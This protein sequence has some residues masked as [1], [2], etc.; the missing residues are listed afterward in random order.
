MPSDFWATFF[1]INFWKNQEFC[2]SMKLEHFTV[3]WFITSIFSFPIFP[4]YF[5]IDDWSDF[6]LLSELNS[7]RI[8]FGILITSKTLDLGQFEKI[9]LRENSRKLRKVGHW[10]VYDQVCP[11]RPKIRT[12]QMIL[13]GL[14]FVWSKIFVRAALIYDRLCR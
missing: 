1:D 6:H 9:S 7:S 14:Y 4:H 5:P 2:K 8:N 3:F 10:W 12:N 13:N 11:G